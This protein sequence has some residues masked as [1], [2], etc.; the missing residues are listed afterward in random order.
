MIML[1]SSTSNF[2]YGVGEFFT[3]RVACS[4]LHIFHVGIY[5]Y[6]VNGYYSHNLIM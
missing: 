3:Y 1:F 6:L 4:A 5:L 2:Y